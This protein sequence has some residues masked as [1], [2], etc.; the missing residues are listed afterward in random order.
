MII[1]ALS[2]T[3]CYKNLLK[4]NVLKQ[5]PHIPIKDSALHFL[6]AILILSHLVLNC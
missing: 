2:F 4:Q 1:L 5:F 3:G 6:A